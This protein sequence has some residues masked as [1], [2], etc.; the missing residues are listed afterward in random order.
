MLKVLSVKLST[1]NGI[2]CGP[3]IMANRIEKLAAK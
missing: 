1:G 2:G 3:K